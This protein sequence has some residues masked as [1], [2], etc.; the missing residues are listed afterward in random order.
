MSQNTRKIEGYLTEVDV[1]MLGR[2]YTLRVISVPLMRGIYHTIIFCDCLGVVH[3]SRGQ[4]GDM[5]RNHKDTVEILTRN[6]PEVPRL[7]A[8]VTGVKFELTIGTLRHPCGEITKE[9]RKPGNDKGE[10]EEEV[11]K[12]V[13]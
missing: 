13:K 9:E 8:Q 7:L 1:E 12:E 5:E 11:F 3:Q 10:K 2:G 4:I 6:H